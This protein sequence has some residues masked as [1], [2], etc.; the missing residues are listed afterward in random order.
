MIDLS[1]RIEHVP[2]LVKRF[3]KMVKS[4][5]RKKTIAEMTVILLAVFDI[6]QFFDVK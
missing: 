1:C 5:V 3:Y 4:G 6:W 2:Y